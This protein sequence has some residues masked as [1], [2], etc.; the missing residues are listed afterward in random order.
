MCSH[1]CQNDAANRAELI[2]ATQRD[3]EL[4]G[5]CVDALEKKLSE[6]TQTIRELR[7]VIRVASAVN[8]EPR[9]ESCSTCAHFRDCHCAVFGMTVHSPEA[10]SCTHGWEAKP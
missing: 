1:E 9:D 7:Q 6:A 8:A 2:A 4:L 10:M 3:N 5:A